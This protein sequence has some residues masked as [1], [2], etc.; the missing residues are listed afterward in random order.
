MKITKGTD[1]NYSKVKVL[2]NNNECLFKGIATEC[3][4][5]GKHKTENNHLIQKASYLERIA[6]KDNVM[7]FDFENRDYI[8]NGG[9]LVRRNLNKANTF[10][11]LCGNHDKYLFDE[12]ENGN[13]FDE[14]NYKQLFQFALRA[15]IFYFSEQELK[16]KFDNIFTKAKRIDDF[17]FHTAEKKRL[18]KYK[19][20]VLEEKWD[21]VETKIIRLRSKV[22]FISCYAGIPHVG[23]IFPF[24]IQNGMIS[25]NIFPEED[26]TIILLSY[27]KDDVGLSTAPGYCEKLVKLSQKNEKRFLKYIN[28]YVIAFDHNIAINPMYWERLSDREK[29]DFY[30]IAHIFPNCK[31]YK[32]YYI[33]YIKLKYKNSSI[34]LFSK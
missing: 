9:Q 4:I 21:S 23:F 20:A 33:G 5:K 8:K 10:R 26:D 15:Y 17:Y 28:K 18:E 1:K 19:R 24:R 32:D 6:Y 14:N 3:S 22:E 11:V 31:S 25:L 30:E 34:N 7:I 2:R 13:K 27:L 29:R 12:I 16:S